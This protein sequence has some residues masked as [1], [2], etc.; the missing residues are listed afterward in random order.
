MRE[1]FQI[2]D[3]LEN[4]IEEALRVINVVMLSDIDRVEVKYQGRL[5]NVLLA[6]QRTGKTTLFS[7][8]KG[9]GTL[10]PD[11][12]EFLSEAIPAA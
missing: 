3:G 12:R 7:T 10:S 2:F 9:F 1:T 8:F 11:I 6:R 5:L 4:N